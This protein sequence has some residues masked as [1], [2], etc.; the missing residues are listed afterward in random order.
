MRATRLAVQVQGVLRG[1]NLRKLHPAVP[2]LD[3]AV[4]GDAR[5]AH[6]P[7][8]R[9]VLRQVL[10]RHLRG[11]T[12]R[13]T[14]PGGDQVTAAAARHTGLH[15]RVKW[16]NRA[17]TPRLLGLQESCKPPP[18]VAGGSLGRGPPDA[19]H[20]GL[21]HQRP[22]GGVRFSKRRACSGA[23]LDSSRART[24]RRGTV[25]CFLA[26]SYIGPVVALRTIAQRLCRHLRW[27]SSS[28]QLQLTLR[29]DL[30]RK[31]PDQS[32]APCCVFIVAGR[33]FFFQCVTRWC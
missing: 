17:I 10:L 30:R 19:S 7:Q 15:E 22:R 33:I 5:R 27:R 28:M 11:G 26:N 12:G 21:I 32:C 13:V 3:H 18:N 24:K 2:G 4:P 23:G 29:A 1:G 8:H 6:H 16:T 20:T 31:V 25:L 14:T 9:K